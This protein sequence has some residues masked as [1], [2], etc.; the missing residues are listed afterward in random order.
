MDSESEQLVQE[1]VERLMTHRTTFVLA[2]RL[3][4]VVNADRIV[5]LLNGRIAESGTHRDLVRARGYYAGLVR[6]QVE[7]L[8]IEAAQM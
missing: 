5:V 4:T 2:H 3:I 6:R 8:L 1:A 7:G